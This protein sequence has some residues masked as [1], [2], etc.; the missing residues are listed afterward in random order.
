MSLLLDRGI[1]VNSDLGGMSALRGSLSAYREDLPDELR[2]GGAKIQTKTCRSALSA[3]HLSGAERK[4]A[5]RKF[6]EVFQR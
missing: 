6:E 5:V 4:V 2:P 3:Y 1:E